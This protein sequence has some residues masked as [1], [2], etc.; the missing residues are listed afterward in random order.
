MRE[1]ERICLRLKQA[2][3]SK[4]IP[5]AELAEK[6]KINKR[7]LE[8]LEECR[9][10]ELGCA[11]IYQ[12]QFIK[13]YVEALNLDAS[14]FLRQFSEEEL[15]FK[16]EKIRHPYKA[17]KKQSFNNVPQLL[18]YGV[19]GAAVFAVLIYLGGQVKNAVEP[20]ALTVLTPPNGFITS[21]HVVS[22]NG[23]TEPE[24]LVSIN[25]VGIVSDEKGNFSQ[26]I[27][28]NEGINTLIIEAEKK[29]GRVTQQTRHIIKKETQK[30]SEAQRPGGFL[31]Q[32]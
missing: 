7:Y 15:T 23:Y 6:T 25:G 18:R 12:K 11:I 16:K 29:H 27:N 24:V 26:H 5:L 22:V 28:L 10:S 20:P 13:K 8:A 32:N 30:F 31:F 1:N 17:Y 9:F 4:G 3:E 2:R 19:V 14:P 21:D